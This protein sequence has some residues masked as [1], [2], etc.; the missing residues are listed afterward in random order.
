MSQKGGQRSSA[1]GF[2]KGNKP[3]VD[4][5]QGKSKKRTSDSEEIVYDLKEFTDEAETRNTPW[6]KLDDQDITFASGEETE[7]HKGPLSDLAKIGTLTMAGVIG[8][9]T[10]YAIAVGNEKLILTLLV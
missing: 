8:A 6:P 10:T 9:V 2:L 4:R 5:F 1:L 3:M 7:T